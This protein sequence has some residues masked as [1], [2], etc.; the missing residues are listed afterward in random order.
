MTVDMH[1]FDDDYV[2]NSNRDSDTILVLDGDEIAFKVSAACEQRGILVTNKTNEAQSAFKHRTEFNNFLAG[3]VIPDGHFEIEDT[4]IAE[5]IKNA[6]ATIKA[7][8]NNYKDKFNTEHMEIYLSGKDNFRD[9]IP[10]PIQY[11]SDR[12][13]SLRP[14][15]LK[16]IRN[17]LSEFQ[18]AVTVQGAY[19]VDDVLGM[20]GYDGYKSGKKIIPFTVDKDALQNSGW[21]YNPDKMIEPQFIEGL[22]ELS[23][24][25]KGKLRGFGRKWLY[26]QWVLGDS[27]DCYN[28]RDIAQQL[29]GKKP[30]FGEKAAYKLLAELT[31]D[32]DCVKAIQDLYI[33]WYGKSDVTYK[34]F[35]GD[36]RT[37]DYIEIMQMYLDCARMLRWEGDKVVVREMLTKMGLL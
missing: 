7:K 13:D 3:L 9:H 36:E 12:K 28:P 10:L 35:K 4:Q 23:I 33:K 20:R 27:T 30:T 29:T 37:V 16:D 15:L 17:Y 34:T 32:K 26:A 24:D 22:G 14:L 6:F 25:D 8:L 18:K 1:E 19:E 21:L 11:K 2:G 5:P 31:T